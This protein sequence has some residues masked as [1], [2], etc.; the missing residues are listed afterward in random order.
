MCCVALGSCSFVVRVERGEALGQEAKRLVICFLLRKLSQD[1]LQRMLST[2]L[3][4]LF[5]LSFSPPLLP[6]Y[7]R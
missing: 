6:V 5:P 7:T 1:P 4:A 3:F 2:L